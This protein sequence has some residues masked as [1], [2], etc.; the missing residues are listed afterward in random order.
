MII[1]IVKLFNGYFNL[2]LDCKKVDRANNNIPTI[3]T[4]GI[5]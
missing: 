1:Q 5:N 4:E 3:Y 2:E